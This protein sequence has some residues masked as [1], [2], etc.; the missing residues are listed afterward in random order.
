M[1]AKARLA[2]TMRESS[3]CTQMPSSIAS[4]SVSHVI[5][6]AHSPACEIGKTGSDDSSFVVI[7]Y[8]SMS[9]PIPSSFF[10]PI[11][12]EQIPCQRRKSGSLFCNTQ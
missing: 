11:S 5:S 8:R 3:D 2:H 12:S 4:N 1:S 6:A 9:A 7:F 10:N